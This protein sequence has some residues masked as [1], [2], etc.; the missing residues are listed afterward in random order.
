M[1]QTPVWAVYPVQQFKDVIYGVSLM[2]LALFAWFL[3]NIVLEWL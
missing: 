2:C 3:F 1:A